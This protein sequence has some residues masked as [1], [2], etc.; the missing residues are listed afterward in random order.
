MHQVRFH[1]L[2]WLDQNSKA[3]LHH[4]QRILML[5]VSFRGIGTRN[6]FTDH[7]F[8][9]LQGITKIS[10]K[11]NSYWNMSSSKQLKDPIDYAS[12]TWCMK[13]LTKIVDWVQ[14]TGPSV[15]PVFYDVT[16]SEV[17]KQSGQFGEAFTEHEERPQNEEIEKI[18]Q[19]VIN[20]LGYNQISSFGDD[21]VD[22]HSGVKRMEDF[23]DLDANEVV[24]VCRPNL[25]ALDL[26][27][28]KNLIEMP[29]LRGVPHI[30]KLNLRECVEI[31]RIDP[32][33]GILKELTYLNLK[34]CE[35]LLVDLNIIFGLNSLEKLNLSGCSKLQ[36]SHLLKKPKETELLENVDINRSAIQSSTSSA[37]KVLMWPFHFLSS[38]K[39][40][41]SFGLLLPYLPSFPCLYSLDLSFCNL[42]KIPDAIGN[43]HSLEDLNLRGNKFVTLPNTIKQ[44][45]KLKYLNLEH[46]KQLKYLPELPTTKEKTLN[47][48]WRWGI[49]AFD[50][51]KL[52][53]MEHCHSMV[54]S[55][56]MQHFK[57][58]LKSSSHYGMNS[59]IPGTKIPRWFIKKNVGSSISMD[60]SRVIEDL[61]CRGVACCAIF[62]AHDDPNNNFDNWRGPPYDYIEFGFENLTNMCSLTF[63]V[64]ILFKRALVTVGF[65]HLLIMFFSRELLTDLARVRSNGLDIVKFVA[66]S[67][68]YYEGLRLEVKSC[69]PSST[70]QIKH[71]VLWKLFIQKAQTINNCLEVDFA[72]V[73]LTSTV[74]ADIIVMTHYPSTEKMFAHRALKLLDGLG[75]VSQT[76]K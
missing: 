75:K 50:C 40:E 22:I 47:Q 35:N 37:L 54:Y 18:V 23:L 11:E 5:F 4:T 20:I 25:G 67:G 71:D 3:A 61:Y 70:I 69:G 33:I 9:A 39:P 56:M 48:Y 38:R 29:D 10:M 72:L 28:S 63:P 44:L 46:C 59:V 68:P 12:S 43:L 7:L 58:Y 51:P 73:N 15:L 19:E 13:E 53:E 74:D 49:Y 31:V 57:V 32:S 24:L 45:S 64:P 66:N 17:R 6:S 8:A 60:L 26:P 76:V 1:L 16:P 55:W 36:N 14:E 52:S 27:Y 34:N 41:E 2:Q 42:L 65:D 30:Q 21:L 62:V